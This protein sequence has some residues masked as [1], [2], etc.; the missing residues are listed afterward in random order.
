MHDLRDS[1]RNAMADGDFGMTLRTG[2]PTTVHTTSGPQQL[3]GIVLTHEGMIK[4]G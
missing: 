1:L 4:T 3:E 2:E